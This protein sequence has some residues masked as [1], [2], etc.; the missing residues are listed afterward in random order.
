MPREND[1]FQL[2]SGLKYFP[3]LKAE[4]FEHPLDKE[5]LN[6]LK[7]VPVLDQV[8]R[9]IN[10]HAI[11]RF[12]YLRNVASNVRVNERMFPGIYEKFQ[13]SMKILDLK[14][15]LRKEGKPE[16][17]L[18]VALVPPT[19]R[20]DPFP[21]AF[22]FGTDQTFIVVTSSLVEMLDDLE[23]FHVIAH[24]LGHIKA[25]HVL[26]QTLAIIIL[27]LLD[28]IKIPGINL[29]IIPLLEWYRRAELTAD[30]AAALCVQ[31]EKVGI[32]VMMKLA[33]GAKRLYEQMDR[34]EFLRQ[35][36][37][38]EERSEHIVDLLS[39]VMLTIYRTHPFAIHRAKELRLWAKSDEYRKIMRKGKQTQ[40]PALKA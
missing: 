1:E 7:K 5:A 9:F 39:K 4:D 8:I 21:N 36:D 11:E 10:K 29:L 27:L 26:Y 19:P 18:Y 16:P 38:Y 30:R 2:P 24:E 13:W 3:G 40:Q 20:P 25:G 22:T 12:F 37:L 28:M 14:A 17:E 23:L 15:D 31:D 6:A 34:E 33:G 32:N 35:V